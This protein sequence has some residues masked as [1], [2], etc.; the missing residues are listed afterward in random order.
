MCEVMGDLLE[1]SR[2]LGVE[3]GMEQGIEQGIEQERTNMIQRM[4]KEK[5]PKEA[6][7]TVVGISEAEYALYVS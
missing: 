2:E 1:R 4:V 7:L 6:I 5:I 3:Q